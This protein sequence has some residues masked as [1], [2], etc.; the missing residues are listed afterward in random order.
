MPLHRLQRQLIDQLTKN[1]RRGRPVTRLDEG[2]WLAVPRR[3]TVDH[4]CI[5]RAVSAV[6]EAG[7]PDPILLG[8]AFEAVAFWAGLSKDLAVTIRQPASR[9]SGEDVH[10]RPSDELH[11]RAH[12]GRAVDEQ[13]A[14]R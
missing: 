10:D 3:L 11:S 9:W 2:G 14:A 13:R 12:V 4:V 7:E 6:G 5:E 1:F 8:L